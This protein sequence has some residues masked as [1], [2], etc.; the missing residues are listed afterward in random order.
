MSAMVPL[1]SSQSRWATVRFGYPGRAGFLRRAVWK[2]VVAAIWSAAS[3]SGVKQCIGW[4]GSI[5]PALLVEY[6]GMLG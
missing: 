1:C 6:P 3:A 2:V 5:N 4:V